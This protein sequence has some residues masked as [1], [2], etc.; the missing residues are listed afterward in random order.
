MS[1]FDLN[2]GD[3]ADPAIRYYA[4]L[5][6]S[7]RDS[8]WAKWLQRALESFRFD[9]DHVGRKTPAGLL[10]K[11]LRP[12]FRDREDFAGGSRLPDATVAALD[13]SAALL[14]LC[15]VASARRPAVNE[16]VRRFRSRHPDRPVIPIIVDD[17]APHNLPPALRYELSSDGAVT[18]RSV[19]VHGPD[20]RDDGD[21]KSLGLAKVI[22]ALTG[23]S[24]DEILRQ[25]EQVR[26]RNRRFWATL[27]GLILV[28]AV[29][30]S[31]SA[32]FVWQQLG[33]N[34]ALLDTTL[35]W[36]TEIIS[37]TAAQAEKYNVSRTPT[38]ALVGKAEGMFSAMAQRGQQTPELRYRRAWMLIQFAR[39]YQI[40][41]DSN[42]Q[43]ARATQAHHL[44]A[45]L[46]AERP[47]DTTYKHELSVAYE[48]IGDVLVAQDKLPEALRA[49]RDGVVI[50][51]QLA[52]VEPTNAVRQRDLEVAYGKIGD[53]LVA[54]N[55]VAEALRFY[56]DGLAIRDWLAK[57]DLSNAGLQRELASSY[58]KVG[59]L[60]M[61]EGNLDRALKSYH[62]GRAVRERLAKTDPSNAVWQRDLSLSYDRI[63][64]LLMGQG[65]LGLALNFYRGGLAIRESLARADPTNAVRQHDLSMSY[66]RIG[67]LLANEGNPGEALKS[68]RDSLAVRESLTKSNPTNVGWQ[69]GLSASHD[70]IGKLL[71]A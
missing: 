4:F 49:Y 50:K 56:R 1:R 15:S 54:Q 25:A 23:I 38:R 42:K 71:L 70:K 39:S 3:M 11:T 40:L 58:D 69:R 37:G 68:Y 9:S 57:R 62:D 46:G 12:I 45:G 44:L 47:E 21:G 35:K 41:G 5:S 19:A 52:K 14:V 22:A 28:L 8:A 6:Y 10:P 51:E 17:T 29:A 60:L 33:T 24:T 55:N 16:E 59:D 36:A 65:N 64:D 20:L 48:E 34:E 63:G 43:Y 31:W 66:D 32:V 61:R 27:A 26:R 18:D 53:L 30:V 7:H 13:A 2:Y 67:D